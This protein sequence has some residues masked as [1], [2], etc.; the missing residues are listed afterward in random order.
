MSDLCGGQVTSPVQ[1]ALG[2]IKGLLL[3]I[4]KFVLYLYLTITTLKTVQY[5]NLGKRVRKM[6]IYIYIYLMCVE[7]LKGYKLIVVG[8]GQQSLC[9]PFYVF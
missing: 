4:S 6:R 5:T 2:K 9:V 7:K 8:T 1:E 3:L